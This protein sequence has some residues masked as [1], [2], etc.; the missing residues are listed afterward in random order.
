[1]DAKLK[2]SDEVFDSFQ[3]QLVPGAHVRR[4][5]A[6]NKS[7]DRTQRKS[8]PLNVAGETR[9]CCLAVLLELCPLREIVNV[10]IHKQQRADLF[11]YQLLKGKRNYSVHG[12]N[13]IQGNGGISADEQAGSQIRTKTIGDLVER[14]VDLLPRKSKIDESLRINVSHLSPFLVEETPVNS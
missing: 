8:S 14:Q 4:D 12:T 2:K 1:V 11:E 13:A 10:S 9:L 7:N 5:S 3:S 6:G